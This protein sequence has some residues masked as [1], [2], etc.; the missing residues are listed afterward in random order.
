MKRTPGS[1]RTASR[2]RRSGGGRRS[3]RRIRCRTAGGPP[4]SSS[5]CRQRPPGRRLRCRPNPRCRS[6]P[7]FR[8][9]PPYR[10][11]SPVPPPPHEAST[12][13]PSNNDARATLMVTPLWFNADIRRRLGT[14]TARLEENAPIRR[15]RRSQNDETDRD[16]ASPSPRTWARRSCR[17]Q[18]ETPAPPSANTRLT[19]TLPRVRVSVGSAAPFNVTVPLTVTAGTSRSSTPSAVN[20]MPARSDP[21]TTRYGGRRR[22]PAA[23]RGVGAQHDIVGSR[24]QRHSVSDVARVAE[25]GGARRATAG[26]QREGQRAAIGA[27]G[28]HGSTLQCDVAAHLDRGSGAH[29]ARHPS[30]VRERARSIRRCK[31]E[32]AAFQPRRTCR[33]PRSERSRRRRSPRGVARG[34]CRAGGAEAGCRTAAAGGPRE[35]QAPAIP[36]R[37]RERLPFK[38]A[39]PV[40]VTARMSTS[41][42]PSD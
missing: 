27:G 21:P 9:C 15:A 16:R 4:C 33:A 13:D 29:P 5:R 19:P 18:N 14:R 37:G 1:C 26:G 42:T 30:S 20:E 36:G 22:D 40:T 35:A 2:S 24:P 17:A 8:S 25:R 6:R 7:P 11:H 3:C 10:S 38:V 32:A 28:R 34:M 12:N 23:E 39:V 31:A 41:S